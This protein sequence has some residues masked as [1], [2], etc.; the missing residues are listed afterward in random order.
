MSDF[1]LTDKT[2]LIAGPFTLCLQNI[3]TKLTEAGTNVTILT[4]DVKGCQ[5]FCQNICDLREVSERFGRAVTLESELTDDK[6]A[7]ELFSKSA[8]I[9]GTSDLYID[10]HMLSLNV[11]FWTNE[12]PDTLT[13]DFT[14]Q[15]G[16]FQ[17]MAAAAAKFIKS[18]NRGRILLLFN[19]LDAISSEKMNFSRFREI[20]ELVSKMGREIGAGAF[21][22][23]INALSLG[24]SEEY[25]TTRFPKIRS[26]QLA[27]QELKKTIP[28]A[29]II[30]HN[31]IANLVLFLVSPLSTGVNGQIIHLDN[32][33]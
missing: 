20:S 18:R 33:L 15:F 26:I 31:D 10:L 7:E 16:N 32:A 24:V 3:T 11:P 30:D 1:K 14:K 28:H 4:N 13:N 25:L 22:T 8:E 2:A 5:R 27:L 23:S 9:F 12:M 21:H 29:K 19:E 6:S 17:K